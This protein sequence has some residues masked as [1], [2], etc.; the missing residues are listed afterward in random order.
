M[1]KMPYRSLPGFHSRPSVKFPNPI[2][3][4]AGIPFANKNTQINTTDRIETHAV[5]KNTYS[6]IFSLY[7]FIALSFHPFLI[8]CFLIGMSYLVASAQVV[9]SPV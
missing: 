5:S 9:I 8:T 2:L 4:M 7:F 3:L 1:G 6:I